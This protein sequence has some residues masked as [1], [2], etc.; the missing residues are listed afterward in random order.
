MTP[1]LATIGGMSAT[2][3]PNE[4]RRIVET[5]DTQQLR[6]RLIDLAAEEAATRA[7]LRAAKA[8]DRM[9]AARREGR[10]DA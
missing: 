8:R 7:L 2:D 9:R 10:R 4:S 1:P 5:L 3:T 6:Q